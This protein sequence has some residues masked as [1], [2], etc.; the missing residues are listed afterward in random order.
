[1]ADVLDFPSREAQAFAFLERQLAALLGSR[2]ADQATIN[3]AIE[4]LKSAYREAEETTDFSFSIDLPSPI[5]ADQAEHLQRQI[6]E[7]IDGLRSHYHGLV[8]K[9]TAQLMLAQ[10]KLYQHERGTK[11][12]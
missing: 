3:F 2:G 9:L 12:E 5:T 8:L 4:A 1:M 11:P 10:L 7:G 6:S